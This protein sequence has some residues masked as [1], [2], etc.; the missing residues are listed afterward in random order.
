MWPGAV[1]TPVQRQASLVASLGAGRGVCCHQRCDD[2]NVGV[3]LVHRPV[4]GQVTI[5]YLGRG[6]RRRKIINKK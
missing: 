5:C 1:Y 4:Q 6:E 3:V 2:V